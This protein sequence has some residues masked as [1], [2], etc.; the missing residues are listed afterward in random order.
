MADDRNKYHVMFEDP[1]S[2]ET[3]G[4]ILDER[5]GAVGRVARLANPYAAKVGGGDTTLADLTEMS[6]YGQTDWRAGRGQDRFDEEDRFYDADRAETR[7]KDQITLGPY[8]KVIGTDVGTGL[9]Y[10]PTN[11]EGHPVAKQGEAYSSHAQQIGTPA[12]PSSTCTHIWLRLRKSAGGQS[13]TYKVALCADDNQ[14]PGTELASVTFDLD[15]LDTVFQDTKFTWD[16]PVSWSGNTYYWIVL[17]KPASGPTS[18]THY[19]EWAKD[20]GQGGTGYNVGAV[21]GWSEQYSQWMASGLSFDFWFSANDDPTA[22]KAEITVN[23]VRYSDDWFCAADDV[24]YIYSSGGG[25]YWSA[26][27]TVA[28]ETVTDLCVAGGYLYAARG[29]GTL[30]RYT[31]TWGDAPGAVT[32]QLL[33]VYNGYLYRT[34][35]T[36]PDTFYYTADGSTWQTVTVGTGETITA[37]AGFRDEVAIATTRGLWLQAADWTYQ[38]LDWSSQEADSNGVGMYAWARTNE[39]FIPV[40]HGL[41]RWTG[42]TMVA[43]GPDRDAGLPSD[44]AGNIVALC[45][46]ANWLYA[47]VDAGSDGY[48]SV[49]VYQGRDWHELYRGG[50]AGERIHTI[51]YE[52]INSPSRLWFGQG[53]QMLYVELPDYSDNPYQYE[54]IH[55]HPDGEVELSAWG[56]ELMPVLKDWRYVIVQA[57]ACN[58]DQYIEVYYEID[59]SGV[60]TLLGT[61]N[62]THT[63]HRISFPANSFAAKTTGSSCTTTTIE[64]GSGDTT[65][66]NGGDWVRIDGEIRQIESITDSDTFVLALPLPSA[67]SSGV[68]VYAAS[69][70][71]S[72]I[73]LRFRLITKDWLKTPR[74]LAV[75]C[76]CQAN[77]LDRWQITLDVLV[78]DRMTCLDGSPYPMDAAALETALQEWITRQTPFTLHDLRETQRTVKVANA[79]ESTPRRSTNVPYS[80]NSVM[81]IGLVEP[82]VGSF[83]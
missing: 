17:Y 51:G 34:D 12:S 1:A 6:A 30:R 15:D 68:T 23:P 41:Y 83:E 62:T 57:E 73:R 69:P 25:G 39:L 81:H 42:A 50:T 40:G 26:S 53:T 56:N 82:E 48:S 54:G 79:V 72:E 18:D 55:F 35:P 60:W 20:I 3:L 19:I 33:M 67:P 61:I 70:L 59:R 75:A 64:L 5:S 44:R 46:T 43:C 32:A 80:Y 36:N 37:M 10:R 31:G 7:I 11:I 74:L 8:I 13:R 21:M 22:L 4:L 78:E 29:T 49:M 71:G 24:V 63:L 9:S 47:V 52:T 45:G 66:M 38:V 2:G 28:G 27:D 16:T 14:K 65:D 77:V 76:F 58:S